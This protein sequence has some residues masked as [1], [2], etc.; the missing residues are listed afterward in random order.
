MWTIHWSTV[1]P[2]I[3]QSLEH[4]HRVHSLVDVINSPQFTSAKASARFPKR[5][6]AFGAVWLRNVQCMSATLCIAMWSARDLSSKHMGFRISLLYSHATRMY[7]RRPVCTHMMSHEHQRQ[8]GM[9]ELKV[10]SVDS[11]GTARISQ[12]TRMLTRGLECNC[13]V[14]Y[15]KIIQG[16][17]ALMLFTLRNGPLLAPKWSARHCPWP[18]LI[19]TTPVS[20]PYIKTVCLAIDVPSL[21][22]KGRY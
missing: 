6:C 9:H 3:G 16:A 21:A 14:Q 4:P 15:C 10:G 5:L 11:V 22:E 8:F 19:N 12:A 2:L 17:V 1:G 18:T 20:V 7:M 13:H